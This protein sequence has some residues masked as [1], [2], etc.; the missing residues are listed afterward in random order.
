LALTRVASTEGHD[1]L[2]QRLPEAIHI[3]DAGWYAK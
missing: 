3:G 2:A 1:E